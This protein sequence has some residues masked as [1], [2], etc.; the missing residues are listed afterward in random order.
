M[1]FFIRLTALLGWWICGVSATSNNLTDLVTWDQYSL[2]I[3]GS[4]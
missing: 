4:R 2:M 3:N 1:Q